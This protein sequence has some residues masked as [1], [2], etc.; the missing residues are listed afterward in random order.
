MKTE[1]IVHGLFSQ[2]S[3]KPD[4][5]Y[6][7]RCSPGLGANRTSTVT[8]RLQLLSWGEVATGA[9]GQ[10]LTL[11]GSSAAPLYKRPDI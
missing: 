3:E 11:K 4:R 8:N 7:G 1:T 2:F 9:E 10:S 5:S 6:K